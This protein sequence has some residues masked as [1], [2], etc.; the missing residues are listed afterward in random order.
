MLIKKITFFTTILFFLIA[1]GYSQSRVVD[2]VVAIVGDE[3][4]LQSEVE[5]QYLDYLSRGARIPNMK[6]KIFEEMLIQKLLLHQAELDSVIIP[7]SQVD[8]QLEQRL[9]HFEKQVG[10]PEKLLKYFNKS[11]RVEL[12]EDL[13][14]IVKEQ[15]ITQKMQSDITENIK[16]TPSETREFYK[17]MPKDSIPLINSKVEINQIVLHPAYTEES[18]FMV[19]QKLL[20]LRK[21]I[22]DGENF[23]ALAVLYSEGPSST[24]GGDIG[25]AAKA[26]LDPEYA[27][28]AFSLK[29]GGISN[30]VES[31]YG[32]HI[33]KLYD[34]KDNKVC[35]RH[36]LIKPKLSYDAMERAVAKLDSIT[37]LIRLDSL[38]FEKAAQKYSDDEDTKANGGLKINQYEGSSSFEMDELSKDEYNIARQMDVGEIS[39][40]FQ[41][42]DKAGKTVYKIV[43]LKSRTEPHRAN[44][45]SDYLTIQEMALANKKQEALVNWVKEK[46]A[47][48][49]IKINPPFDKCQYNLP[50][51]KN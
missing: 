9:Q 30:I 39:E 17:E 5:Q 27:K 34:R 44:L 23:N 11:S 19:K 20:D 25:C 12:K 40:P 35:T 45:Q 32:Y 2:Q 38:T 16:I 26:E 48:V 43:R 3:V 37:R 46:Q 51:W 29:P 49:F 22:L 10:S 24:Q 47:T 31:E 7:E 18:V 1:N 13:R 33:I 36:I 50:G 28:A 41:T 8:M 6:C 14:E 4:V 42:V 21:R 15:L